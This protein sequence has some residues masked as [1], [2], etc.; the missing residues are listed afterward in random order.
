MQ[1]ALDVSAALAAARSDPRRAAR[2][3][4]AAYAQ[5]GLSGVRRDAADARFLEPRIAATRAA[6]GEMHFAAAESQGRLLDARQALREAQAW[7]QAAPSGAANDS[8]ALTASR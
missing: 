4:G 2:F 5:A 7:L 6:L 8:E 1:S 3:V